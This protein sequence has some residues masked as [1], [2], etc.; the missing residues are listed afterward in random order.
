MTLRFAGS[1]ILYLYKKGETAQ[2]SALVAFSDGATVDESGSASWASATPGVATVS[3]T[4]MVTA[5]DDGGSVITA[6]FQTI[7]SSMTVVVD[8]PT[9]PATH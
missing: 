3:S 5:I 2:L 1:S 4:G 8:L 6:T 9:A 7:G